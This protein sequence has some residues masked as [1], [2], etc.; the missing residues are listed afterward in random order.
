MKRDMDL[1]RAIILYLQR[2]KEYDLEEFYEEFRSNGYDIPVVKE[3]VYLLVE[4]GYV[5]G[6]GCLENGLYMALRLTWHGHEF[7]DTINSDR[8][9]GD[10]KDRV[11]RLGGSFSFEIVKELGAEL[12]KRIVFS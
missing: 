12:A 10:V 4:A 1:I 8:V 6:D 5:E 7:I 2:D 11:K 3:H 9:W